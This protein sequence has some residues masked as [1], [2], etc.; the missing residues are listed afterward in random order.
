MGAR[1]YVGNLSRDT[2][3][4]TVRRLCSDGGRSVV[5]ID[6]VNDRGGTGRQRGF[7]FVDFANEEDARAAIGALNGVMQGGRP[8]TVNEARERDD[9]GGR[10]GGGSWGRRGGS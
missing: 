4:E 3:E 5:K 8:L 2:D 9:R 1:V 10:R 6:M 7:A